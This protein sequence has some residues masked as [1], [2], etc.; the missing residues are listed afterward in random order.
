MPSDRMVGAGGWQGLLV[1][2]IV[3]PDQGGANVS[4]LHQQFGGHH[5][6]RDRA[7]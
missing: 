1:V 5:A 4:Q 2:E 3:S 6:D 7:P